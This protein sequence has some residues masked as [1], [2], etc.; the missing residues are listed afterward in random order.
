MRRPEPESARPR[1][2]SGPCAV[3][4]AVSAALLAACAGGVTDERPAGALAPTATGFPQ[5]PLTLLAPANP[6]GGWDQTARQIQQVW[7]E[8]GILG[9]PVEVVNRGGAGGTIGLADLVTRQRGDP[10]TVMVFGQV[11]LGSHPHQPIARLDRRRGAARAAA[12][13]V[14]GDCGARRLASP[15]PRR[16]RAGP[17]GRARARELGRRIGRGHRPHA[18]RPA[19]PRRRGRPHPRELRGPLG[20]R[21]GG[22]GGDG[23]AR[24]RGHLRLRRVEGPRRGGAACGC[25]RCRRPS[26]SREATSRPSARAG[27]TW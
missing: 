15:E 26:A 22:G 18:G 8:A 25:S 16:P 3:A 11:M 6:G 21:R 7:T 12:R 1:P 14:R 24:H 9:V 13:R 5:G 20:R 27:S 23:G 10:H 19:R 4:V 2:P 17:P